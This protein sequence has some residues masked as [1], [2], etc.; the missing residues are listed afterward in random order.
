MS[1]TFTPVTLILRLFST[2][3]PLTWTW[4]AGP[5]WLACPSST[6]RSCW[7][8]ARADELW[9]GAEYT[10]L[11]AG[12][13]QSHQ[14]L[15]LGLGR[16][17]QADVV[18]LRWPDNILQAECSQPSGAVIRLEETDRR[19]SSCPVLFAWNG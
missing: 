19:P 14:P 5:T 17:D 10:T 18:E 3:R 16:H 12:L 9:T 1:L 6:N 7:A 13:G 2:P 4:T 15:I 11:S 8:T